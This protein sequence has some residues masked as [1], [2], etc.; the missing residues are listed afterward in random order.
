M[1]FFS[2]FLAV[3]SSPVMRVLMSLHY[4]NMKRRPRTREGTGKRNYHSKYSGAWVFESVAS[5]LILYNTQ[6]KQAMQLFLF[7][8]A[9]REV[10][11]LDDK[12]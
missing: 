3:D 1:S 4:T 6:R 8:E 11:H 10:F 12:L 7:G 5:V 9:I 2:S